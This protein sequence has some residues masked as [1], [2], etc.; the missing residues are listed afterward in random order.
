MNNPLFITF[1]GGEGAGKS[2]QIKAVAEHLSAEGRKPVVTREPGGTPAGEK[3]RGLL[4]DPDLGP[5]WSPES[6]AMLLNAARHMHVKDIIRPALDKGQIVLCDRY[7]DS[8]RVYQGFIQGLE[9]DFIHRLEDDIIGKIRPDLT[10]I[11]DL[12]V[13][14]ALERVNRRGT[15]DHYDQ[16]DAAFHEQLRQGFLDIAAQEP[17]RCRV[18]DADR[19]PVDITQEICEIITEKLT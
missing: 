14:K 19:N 10:F 5:K 18:I 12:P 9:T 11:L 17:E 7:I 2:T 15:L 3:I 16:G 13:E 1:E 4:C 6:E 8:T